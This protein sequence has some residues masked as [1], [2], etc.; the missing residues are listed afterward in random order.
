MKKYKQKEIK[1]FVN[2]FDAP[3]SLSESEIKEFEKVAKEFDK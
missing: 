1:D 2:E 3:H